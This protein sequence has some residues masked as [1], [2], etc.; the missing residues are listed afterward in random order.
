MPMILLPFYE[1]DVK[2][3]TIGKARTPFSS[4]LP[5][6]SLVYC[7]RQIKTIKLLV[8]FILGGFFHRWYINFVRY[9]GKKTGEDMT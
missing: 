3:M 5:R 7:S 1:D 9:S 6:P 4:D 2:V 8:L